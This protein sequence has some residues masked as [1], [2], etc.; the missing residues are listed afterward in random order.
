MKKLRRRRVTMKRKRKTAMKKVML[1]PTEARARDVKIGHLMSLGCGVDID[2]FYGPFTTAEIKA[3]HYFIG[4]DGEGDAYPP[5]DS[6][7]VY[8]VEPDAQPES[9]HYV[10]ADRYFVVVGTLGPDE[11]FWDVFGSFESRAKATKYA[12]DHGGTLIKAKRLPALD[13]VR[14]NLEFEVYLQEWQEAN[15]DNKFP[16]SGCRIIYVPSYRVG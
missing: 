16:K 1:T 10:S 13:H 15:R 8:G 7:W 11:A 5:W 12:D 14:K 2:N 9:L 4:D 6:F 3:A